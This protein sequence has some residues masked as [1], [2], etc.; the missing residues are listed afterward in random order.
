M[1]RCPPGFLRGGWWLGLL[2]LVGAS[3][4]PSLA[5]AHP[6]PYTAVM[7]DFGPGGV[8][9]E[10]I[11]PLQELELGFKQ[12][13]LAHPEQILPQDGPA[14]REYLLA[15]VHPVTPDGRPWTVQVTGLSVQCKE[16]PFDLMAHLWMQPPPGAPLRQFKFNYDV[17]VH[18]VISHKAFVFVRNDWNEARFQPGGARCRRCP[19]RSA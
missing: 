12:P 6:M 4:L 17:I 19:R 1:K 11:L 15:H 8:S 14:L 13:M 9:A 7:L 18:E 3:L 2:A 5:T 16:I 10:L